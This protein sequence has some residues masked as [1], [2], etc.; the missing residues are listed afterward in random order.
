MKLTGSNS[1]EAHVQEDVFVTLSRCG[2][3]TARQ[4]SVYKSFMSEAE[5]ARNA[6]YR[7]ERDRHRDLVARGLLRT[8]LAQKLGVGP[9]ELVFS[10]GEHGKPVLEAAGRVAV[11]EDLHFNLS[12]A[13]DWVVLATAKKR[14]GIDIEYTPRDNDVMAIAER[15]FFGAEFEELCA[16]A[17]AEQKQRF[18]DYWTLKEAYMK[19]RG[20]GISL[21]LDNFG[22]SV[23]PEQI[24][25]YIAPAL[26]DDPR[27]WQFRCATPERDY[28][29]ALALNTDASPNIISCERIPLQP[30]RSLNWTIG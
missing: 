13:E 6:R 19:A 3:V 29:L 9:E 27:R 24:S 11:P 1:A 23:K 26:E 10:Q 25:I 12:H 14:V 7:F 30:A 8:E 16:F 15:Y 22:F 5:L 20:E 2:D 4:A 18:F 17:A 21:G 28:R